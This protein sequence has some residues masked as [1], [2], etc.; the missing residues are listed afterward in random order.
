MS[1]VV[2]FDANKWQNELKE[3]IRNQVMESLPPEMIDS[4]LTQQIKEVQDS[5]I[6]EKVR[7][8]L[9]KTVKSHVEKYVDDG[10]AWG[11]NQISDVVARMVRENFHEIA[12]SWVEG[13]VQN[14]FNQMNIQRGY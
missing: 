2:K 10:R 6:K 8:E 9:D 7:A 14:V 4:L 11:Q 1:D 13:V 12:R 5:V 3:K